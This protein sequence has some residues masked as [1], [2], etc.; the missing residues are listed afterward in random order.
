MRTMLFN[1]V[2]TVLLGLTV[3]WGA[4]LDVQPSEPAISAEISA[5][6]VRSA[7]IPPMLKWLRFLGWYWECT[8]SGCCDGTWPSDDAGPPIVCDSDSELAVQGGQWVC[9]DVDT[10]S[11]TDVCDEYES[12]DPDLDACCP[13]NIWIASCAECPPGTHNVEESVYDDQGCLEGIGCGCEPD[14]CSDG[15]DVLCDMLPPDCANGTVVAVQNGC[16][17]C[18]DPDTCAPP[19]CPNGT[20]FDENVGH[21][22]P[23][24]IW[25]EDCLCPAGTELRQHRE[26]GDAGCLVGVGCE[27]V[28]TCH[29]GSPLMCDMTRPTCPSGQI[30]SVQNGCWEC[31]DPDTCAPPTCPD[32]ERWDGDLGACCPEA[33]WIADCACPAGANP[34]AFDVFDDSGCFVGQGCECEPSPCDDGSLNADGQCHPCLDPAGAIPGDCPTD[35]PPG[36]ALTDDGECVY[37]CDDGTVADPAGDC[38]VCPP[39]MVL[40]DDGTC[41]PVCPDGTIADANGSCPPSNDCTITAAGDVFCPATG[42]C[43]NGACP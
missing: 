13:D 18:V 15:G 29:D 42:D 7:G 2:M 16:Y 14:L 38:P 28:P 36:T 19:E 22:C 41:W 17:Q 3:A 9:A 1:A 30:A 20:H 35:C 8:D 11:V 24:S 43:A 40:F 31:V 10:C 34:I 25:V 39:D 37:L 21:C 33:T 26:F 23:S 27:C 5:V 6:T 32:G 12:W 4:T